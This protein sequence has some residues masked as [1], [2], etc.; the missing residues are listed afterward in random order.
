MFS[1]R[2]EVDVQAHLYHCIILS[3]PENYRDDKLLVVTTEWKIPNDGRL[4]DLAIVR[5]KKAQ[6]SDAR[7]GTDELRLLIEM[8]ETGEA[9]LEGV[10]VL[11]RIQGDLDKMTEAMET[12][13]TWVSEYTRN[14]PVMAFFFRGASRRGLPT[15][16]AREM[17][18]VAKDIASRAVFL[19]GPL[20]TQ[21][22]F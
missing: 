9:E 8:K 12:R 14:P 10:E 7:K 6:A 16:V 1:P 18:K 22:T 13:N 4:V 21:G 15:G 2:N 11:G 5:V 17:D 19:Y 20:G 3:R